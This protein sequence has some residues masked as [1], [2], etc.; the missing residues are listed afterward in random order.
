MLLEHQISILEWFRRWTLDEWC[1]K[2]QLCHYR[3]KFSFKWY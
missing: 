2:M 1:F 3:N